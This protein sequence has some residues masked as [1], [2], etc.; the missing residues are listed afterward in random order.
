MSWTVE[1][2]KIVKAVADPKGTSIGKMKADIETSKEF[3]DSFKRAR[4]KN[5]ACKVKPRVTAQSKGTVSVYKGVFA[6][7]G[8]AVASGKVISIVPAKDGNV[9]EIRNTKMG[10]FITPVV[11]CE[12]L[13][14]V[15]AGFIPA[16][17]RI[18]SNLLVKII[19][20]FRYFMRHG[21]N[22][23]VLLNIYWD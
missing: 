11:G 3:L 9:Y 13:S 12:L 7:M 4:D 20:F 22:N 14:D 18:P 6:N 16:L 21:A 8:D 2:G 17:P 10:Q 23:E 5:P 1:Y 15:R 19:A